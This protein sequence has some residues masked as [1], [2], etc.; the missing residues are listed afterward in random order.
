MPSKA[1]DFKVDSA[2]SK[3]KLP[4]Q[5]QL[6]RNKRVNRQRAEE[7]RKSWGEQ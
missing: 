4:L 6:M 2:P 5:V 7:L 3:T 1:S